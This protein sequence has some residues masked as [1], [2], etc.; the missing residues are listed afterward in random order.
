MPFDPCD[1]VLFSDGT[2]EGR[3][4]QQIQVKGITASIYVSLVDLSP[5]E[6]LHSGVRRLVI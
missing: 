5:P 2:R 3:S 1:Q 6:R 4:R